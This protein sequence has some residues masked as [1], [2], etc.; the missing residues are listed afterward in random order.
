M[1]KWKAHQGKI[2]SSAI[3]NYKNEQFYIT[4]AND[5]DISIWA[6]KDE[7]TSAINNAEDGED[8]LISTLREFISYKTISSRPEFAEDC[9]KGATF[10]ACSSSDLVAT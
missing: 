1:S 5:D 9:R 8:V 7:T 6:I 3:T 2:L 4:G 10:L